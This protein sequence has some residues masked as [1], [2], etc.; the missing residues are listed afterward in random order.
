MRTIATLAV[1]FAVAGCGGSS[2]DA[3]KAGINTPASAPAVFNREP[4]GKGN[5]AT[6]WQEFGGNQIAADERYVGKYLAVTGMVKEVKKGAKD[7]R[8]YV[9]FWGCYGSGFGTTG[10]ETRDHLPGVICYIAEGKAGE[11]GSVQPDQTVTVV[12]KVAEKR[13]APLAAYQDYIVVLE[14]ATLSK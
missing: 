14:D 13:R 1:V 10:R 8:Y 3:G 9:G 11:F 7:G 2:G 5:A 6:L 4:V 12:A